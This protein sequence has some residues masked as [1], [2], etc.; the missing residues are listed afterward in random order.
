[1]SVISNNAGCN[2]FYQI[3]K[4]R[5][6][7]N[8]ASEDSWSTIECIM[9]SGHDDIRE[10]ALRISIVDRAEWSSLVSCW[11]PPKSTIPCTH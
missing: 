1:M 7:C 3:C 5:R 6:Q 9:S 2:V 11:F 10:C 4:C 8:V